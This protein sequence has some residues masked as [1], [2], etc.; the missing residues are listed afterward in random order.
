VVL[1]RILVNNVRDNC[2]GICTGYLDAAG[3]EQEDDLARA[4]EP[5]HSLVD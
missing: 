2:Y 5:A 1:I 3:R 4:A